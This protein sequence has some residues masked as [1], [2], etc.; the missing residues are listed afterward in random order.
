MIV[1]LWHFTATQNI[2]SIREEGFRLGPNR[3][4]N[5]FS[6][7]GD[8]SCKGAWGP[9][10]VEVW[11]EIDEQELAGFKYGIGS[12]G[13]MYIPADD[14]ITRLPCERFARL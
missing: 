7:A 1:H 9:G 14:S 11:L 13:V 3:P 6:P 2:K 10:L 12:D 5:Y 4:G 8:M